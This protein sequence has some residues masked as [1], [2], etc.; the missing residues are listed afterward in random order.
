MTSDRHVTSLK[1]SWEERAA[2]KGNSLEGVLYRGFSPALNHYIHEWHVWA[3]LNK[4]LAHLPPG[5]SVL[6]LACGYGR[7]RREAA[8]A[9]PDLHIQGVD[10]SENYCREHS[11]AFGGNTTCADMTKLPFATGTFDA[12]I[13]VTALMYL[14]PATRGDSVAQI[15][16]LL[17]PDGYALFI[18]PGSEFMRIARLGIRPSRRT[19]TGGEGLSL[20]MQRHLGDP[21][22]YQIEAIGGIPMFTWLLPLLYLLKS[23]VRWIRPLLYMARGCD[24]RA[25]IFLRFSLQR[26]ILIK[27]R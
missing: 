17:K 24:R 16:A 23:Q 18:D 1:E 7:I 27:R 20:S 25:R 4:L 5:S 22:R 15:L 21:A 19:P 11:R 6:D 26:W 10:F 13:G 2:A 9:R 14:S 8:A 3:V 12:V